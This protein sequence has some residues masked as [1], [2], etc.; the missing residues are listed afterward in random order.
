MGKKDHEGYVAEF[1]KNINGV[2]VAIIIDEMQ[3][4]DNDCMFIAANFAVGN[5]SGIGEVISNRIKTDLSESA[6][7]YAR[8]K[9]F[10]N[11][12]RPVL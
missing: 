12:V 1:F 5:M 7:N 6:D 9:L 3:Y 2:D 10:E 8:E 4:D 11:N